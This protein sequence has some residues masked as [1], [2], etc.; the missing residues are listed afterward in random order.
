MSESLDRL[1]LEQ[2]HGSTT[3]VNTPDKAM[4]SRVACSIVRYNIEKKVGESGYFLK[5]LTVFSRSVKSRRL[6]VSVV[7]MP[8]LSQPEAA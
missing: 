7:G 8:R 2:K 5:P 4:T 1:F 6:R 3:L